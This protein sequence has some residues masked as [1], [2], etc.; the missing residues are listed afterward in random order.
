MEWANK[1]GSLQP[2]RPRRE[3]K[4]WAALET[5]PPHVR[6]C[7]K[8]QLLPMPAPCATY[9]M[10]LS[11]MLCSQAFS[12]LRLAGRPSKQDLRATLKIS[13]KDKSTLRERISYNAK[14]RKFRSDAGK[15]DVIPH[16]ILCSYDLPGV[17]ATCA[18]E[19]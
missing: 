14:R 16:L 17:G 6:P 11:H 8:K 2:S 3:G 19:K 1:A 4:R 10:V 9:Q 18:R 12:C 5:Y 7:L 13:S 15:P